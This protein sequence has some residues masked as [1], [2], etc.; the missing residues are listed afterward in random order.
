MWW[1]GTG[2]VAAGGLAWLQPYDGNFIVLDADGAAKW[3]S[4]VKGHV[5]VMQYDCN[6]VI[7]NEGGH[8]VWAS[9]TGG[10]C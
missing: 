6:L 4:N 7:Y 2:G 10:W 9:G 3:A 5:V 8:V 1:S